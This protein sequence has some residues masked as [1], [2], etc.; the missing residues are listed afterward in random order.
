ML[1]TAVLYYSQSSMECRPLSLCR[2]YQKRLV[3][4]NFILENGS[5]VAVHN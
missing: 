1:S 5:A 2:R 4:G 3:I